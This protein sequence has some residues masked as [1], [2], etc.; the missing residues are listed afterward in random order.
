M[1]DR[2]RA[3]WGGERARVASRGGLWGDVGVPAPRGDPPAARDRVR[4]LA[5]GPERPGAPCAR[6]CGRLRSGRGV[7]PLA[8]PRAGDADLE[9]A[10]AAARGDTDLPGGGAISQHARF[11]CAGSGCS[12]RFRGISG[13]ARGV[14]AIARAAPLLGTASTRPRRPPALPRARW[15]SSRSGS[16]TSGSI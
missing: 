4:S 16:D 13:G 1:V 2:R 9:G 10:R 12:P 15:L 3:R 7:G 8:R 14:R 11:S 6:R 5:N